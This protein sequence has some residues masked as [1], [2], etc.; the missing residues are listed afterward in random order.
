MVLLCGIP[1]GLQ[2]SL[3]GYVDQLGSISKV[4]VY[5][6]NWLGTQAYENKKG[7]V[8]EPRHF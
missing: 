3:T 7:K 6:K 8:P 5:T 1:C 2:G 4:Y